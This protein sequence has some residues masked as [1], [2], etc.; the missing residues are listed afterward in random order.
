MGTDT[1]DFIIWN[2]YVEQ[3]DGSEEEVETK[4]PAVFE[5]C[6]GCRGKG[7]HVHPDIDGNGISQ[8]EWADWDFEDRENYMS[9]RYDVVCRTCGGERVIKVVDWDYLKTHDPKLM[10]EYERYLDEEAAYHRM[11]EMERR[12]GA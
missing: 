10:E 1:N 8:D 2:R 9:G 4:I 7:T 3:E 12:Y 6:D 5:V 11:C